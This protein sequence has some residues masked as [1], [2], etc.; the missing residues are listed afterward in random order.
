MD[1]TV[2]GTRLTLADDAQAGVTLPFTFRYYG[3]SFTS[4]TA[5]SNGFLVFGSSPPAT[6]WIN[7]PLPN[8]ALPNGVV[9][10]YW[11]DLNP[12]LGGG[13]LHRNVGTAPNRKLVVSWVGVRHAD[14][15]GPISFQ[16]VPRGGEQRRSCSPTRTPWT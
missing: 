11:D 4:V 7:T 9:A 12:A 2:G 13:V 6:A 14:V 10:A 1:A 15:A 3:Q 16:I 8:A 5:S